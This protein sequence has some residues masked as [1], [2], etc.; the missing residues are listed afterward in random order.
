[1]TNKTSNS[2]E[3]RELKGGHSNIAFDYRIIAKRNGYE[4]IRLEDKT[5]MMKAVPARVARL[6]RKPAAKAP[7]DG[8]APARLP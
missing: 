2:F 3:V 4:Q 1:V 7:S 6:G 8:S 5:A